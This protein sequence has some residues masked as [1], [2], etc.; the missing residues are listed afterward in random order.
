MKKIV[1]KP[2]RKA[3][4]GEGVK[5]APMVLYSSEGDKY[6]VDTTG[7]AKK[8][9]NFYPYTKTVPAGARFKGVFDRYDMDQ[10]MPKSIKKSGTGAASVGASKVTKAVKSKI[11]QKAKGGTI[12]SKTTKKK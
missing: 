7:Y 9:N 11:V 10:V 5:G 2:L 4:K 3:Q 6:E 12:K 1:K 8:K